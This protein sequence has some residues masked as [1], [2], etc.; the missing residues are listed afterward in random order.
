MPFL[1]WV[2]KRQ[3]TQAAHDVLYNLPR[4]VSARGEVRFDIE[5]KKT[6]FKSF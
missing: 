6:F 4:Q 5:L 1:D 3:A 2:N